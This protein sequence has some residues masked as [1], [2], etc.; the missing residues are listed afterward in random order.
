MAY[1]KPKRR[2]AKS[3]NRSSGSGSR[4]STSSRSTG[5]QTKSGGRGAG[6]GIHTVRIVME[7]APAG[8][9]ANAAVSGYPFKAPEPKKRPKAKR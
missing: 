4:R 3:N 7:T 1:G 9:V 8:G 6:S 2:V 5:R